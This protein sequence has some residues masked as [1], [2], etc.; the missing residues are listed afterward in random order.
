MRINSSCSTI[1][2]Y[3]SRDMR[4][5]WLRSSYDQES[6]NCAPSWGTCQDT[7]RR[8][9]KSKG[10]NSWWSAGWKVSNWA[11]SYFLS[12]TECEI[13]SRDLICSLPIV[14]LNESWSSSNVL[15]T[16]RWSSKKRGK[17]WNFKNFMKKSSSKLRMKALVGW[18]TLY[19][20]P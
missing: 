2:K 10:I 16:V 12:D 1:W 3:L 6:I 9:I 11:V 7:S 18:N 14:R 4:T 8:I 19:Q 5:W 20:V 13:I 17:D 15:G